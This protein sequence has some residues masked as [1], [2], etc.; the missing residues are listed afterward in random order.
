MRKAEL[1]VTH[2]CVLNRLLAPHGPRILETV[3]LLHGGRV[4]QMHAVTKSYP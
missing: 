3:I 2:A 1:G 4:G